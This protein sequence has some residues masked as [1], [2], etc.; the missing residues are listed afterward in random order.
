MS[1]HNVAVSFASSAAQKWRV[2][3][4]ERIEYAAK[5]NIEWILALPSKHRDALS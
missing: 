5:V 4:I 2:G 1:T 3:A